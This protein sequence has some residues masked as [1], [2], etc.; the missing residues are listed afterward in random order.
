[1]AAGNYGKLL[2][3]DLSEGNIKDYQIPESYLVEYIGG[4][5]LGARLLWDLL[6]QNGNTDPYGKENV[7]LILLGPLAGLSVMGSARYVAMTKSPLSKFVTEAYGGGFF[8]YAL[9][10]TGYDGIIIR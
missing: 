10:S 6:P 5:G 7:L 9:K 4:K 3:V 1:M 8:P 2:D